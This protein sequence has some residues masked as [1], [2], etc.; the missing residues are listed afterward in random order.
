MIFFVAKIMGCTFRYKESFSLFSKYLDSVLVL[1]LF[2]FTTALIIIGFNQFTFII[3]FKIDLP[4]LVSSTNAEARDIHAL[5]HADENEAD[6][7]L[8]MKQV[9]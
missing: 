4:N 5:K 7:D 8:G 3:Y 6:T 2:V 9:I 1:I